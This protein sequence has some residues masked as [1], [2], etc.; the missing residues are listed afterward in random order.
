MLDAVTPL[1]MCVCGRGGEI[2]QLQALPNYNPYMMCVYC[3]MLIW[4]RGCGMSKWCN[5]EWAAVAKP[6]VKW[7]I[8]PKL[9][10]SKHPLQF[11]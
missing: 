4:R 8:K 11:S 6:H 7:M 10:D 1:T 3:I 9:P 5:Y 2:T